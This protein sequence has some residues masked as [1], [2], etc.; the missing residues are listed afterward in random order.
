VKDLSS[1]SDVVLVIGSDNSS[2]SKRLVEVAR[3]FG[4]PAYLID[5]ESE[6]DPAWL[7]GAE[8]VGVTSGASA[9]EW[10]VERVVEHLRALGATEVEQLRTVEEQMF[11][12]L[13]AQVRQPVASAIRSLP[14]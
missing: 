1:R 7:R 11:F 8:T 3:A 14:G 4:T 9:P 12:S 13:P 10:L 6:L 2:N 5:D